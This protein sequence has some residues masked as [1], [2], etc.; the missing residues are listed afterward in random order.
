MGSAQAQSQVWGVQARNW[1]D[2]MEKMAL[3]I[4]LLP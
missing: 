4:T 3:P 1:A 2:L